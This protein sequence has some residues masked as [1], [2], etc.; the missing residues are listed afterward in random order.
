MYFAVVFGFSLLGDGFSRFFTKDLYVRNVYY[1]YVCL[2]GYLGG[3]CIMAENDRLNL[4]ITEERR[5][6]LNKCR[7]NFSENTN[8]KAIE[9]AM[10]L[11]VNYFEVKEDLH[12]NSIEMAR[13]NP[14]KK[15]EN[16]KGTGYSK[17]S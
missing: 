5:K 15:V 4:I 8:S 10:K 13:I 12:L 14:G 9:K 3:M 16:I 6:L 17:N 1:Y 11:A 7:M 2:S